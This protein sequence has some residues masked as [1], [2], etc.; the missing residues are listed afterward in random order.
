MKTRLLFILFSG[1]YSFCT[2]QSKMFT[3]LIPVGYVLLDSASG[4]L[5]KD[6]YRDLLL[7]LKTSD[8][9][10]FSEKLRPLLILHG[11]KTKK[12]TLIARNDNVVLCNGCGGVF[13]DPYTGL[14]I[15]NSYFSAEHYGGSNWRWTRIMTFKYDLKTKTYLLH[16]DAGESYHMSDLDKTTQNVNRKQ[17]FG[18]LPFTKYN[19]KLDQ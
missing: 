12:Y 2:A 9:E 6:G 13:G 16:R 4:D 7:V 15:K 8:E 10:N 3:A 19:S 17:D 1:M 5:N 14:V 11:D 18:K